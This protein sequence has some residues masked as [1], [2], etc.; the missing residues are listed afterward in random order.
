MLNPVVEEVQREDG[1]TRAGGAADQRGAPNR[2]AA[3]TDVI[4]A[5]DA[6]WQLLDLR[7]T[8]LGGRIRHRW[9]G[10]NARLFRKIVKD[11]SVGIITEFLIQKIQAN[12]HPLTV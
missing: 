4:K 8:H 5:L 7:Q 9:R 6:G 2:Q 11:L 1:F 3:F 10:H 12:Q